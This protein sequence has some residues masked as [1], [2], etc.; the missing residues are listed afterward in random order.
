MNEFTR[1][2]IQERYGNTTVAPQSTGGYYQP[3]KRYTIEGPYTGGRT[4]GF[5][6]N[7]EMRM[8]GYREEPYNHYGEYEMPYN[9]QH[10][11]YASSKRYDDDEE[12]SLT[13][14]D[15][16]HWIDKLK[17]T[18][19]THG[20]HFS[21]ERIEEVAEKLNIRFKHFNLH[22]LYMTANMLYSDYA[23]VLKVY[24][25]KDSETEAML[26]VKL[27]KAF[28]EDED[29]PSGSEKLALYYHCIACDK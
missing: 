12:M 4:I 23:A 22:E 2:L 11:S 15:I 17:N 7:N 8:G 21:K 1:R 18:D 27:A 6:D 26:Y 14:K 28:L 9:E 5:R 13:K 16:Q 19:G 25:I 10:H 24:V 3:A 20:E 29:A